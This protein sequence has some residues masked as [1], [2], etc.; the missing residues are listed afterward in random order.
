MN[1]KRGGYIKIVVSA[2]VAMWVLAGVGCATF[3]GDIPVETAVPEVTYIS[4]KGGDGIQDTLRVRLSVPETKG[5]Q[6]TGYR[7]VVEDGTG[8]VVF[9]AEESVTA[10]KGI[11]GWF[12]RLT[13]TI[14]EYLEW[15]GRDMN[16]AFVDDGKYSWYGEAWDPKGNHGKTEPLAV[17]VDNTPPS[18]TVSMPFRVISPDGDGNQDLLPVGQ[19]D[20]SIEDSWKGT[21]R[22]GSGAVVRTFEWEGV[23]GNFQWDGT[24][25]SGKKLPDGTYSYVLAATDRAGNSGSVSV[26]GIG[27]DTRKSTV[28]IKASI[29][30]FSPNGDGVRDLVT[31][32]PSAE[33]ASDI[34]ESTIEVVNEAGDSVLSVRTPG[35]FSEPLRFTGVDSQNRLLPEGSYYGVY[36]VTYRNGNAPKAVSNPVF[37]DLTPPAIAIRASYLTFSPDGDGR[38]DTLKI[39]QSSSSEETWEGAILDR[40]GKVVVKR[41]FTEGVLPFEWDG[42][43]L[44]GNVV[45]DGTYRYRAG[46]TDEAG[47]LTIRE[48]TNIVVDTRPTP[49]TIIAADKTFSPN[50]DGRF[51]TVKFFVRTTISEGISS[52]TVEIADRDGRIV[53]TFAGG[54]GPITDDVVWDGR[55]ASGAAAPE[56]AYKA[57][58]TVSYDKGNLAVQEAE[59]SVSLDTTGPKIT[60][61]LKGIPFSPDKDG[62]ND[63]LTIGMTMEDP[64]PVLLWNADIVDPA[65][66]PFAAFSGKGNPAPLVWDGRSADGELVQSAEDYRLDISAMDSVGNRSAVTSTIP[67]DILVMKEGDQYRIII[68]SVYFEPYTADYLSLEPNIVARNLKT[69]DRLAEVLKKYP[70]YRI[71]IEGHAVRVLWDQ[72]EKWKTEE[73]EILMPLSVLRAAVIRDALVERGIELA[74]LSITG[75]GGYKPVVPHSDM[76]N[77]WKNRRVEFVLFK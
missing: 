5:L 38:K 16:G 70:A 51:D 13:V 62:T 26:T 63:L 49:V 1:V 31:F 6:V 55:D 22:N 34:L 41:T 7:F 28:G 72:K 52:W 14:P 21:F 69:L 15:D 58:L 32:F 54:P 56:G 46:S 68:S 3:N 11:A 66:T 45:P 27:V 9:S 75:F 77:R 20:G 25:D 57:R 42:R 53:R 36:T 18:A 17:I 19:K 8:N 2:L 74:R 47:N 23:P 73:D 59:S 33:L 35:G 71:R 39:E 65:G 67:V 64:S 76:V 4:P 61:A 10:P 40:S 43:D 29:R 48:L 50:G 60:V 30:F 24:D 12:S 44:A 37:L